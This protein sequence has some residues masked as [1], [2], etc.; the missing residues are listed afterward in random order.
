MSLVA[1]DILAAAEAFASPPL[2]H[3]A[4]AWASLRA[5]HKILWQGPGP[6]G[7]CAAPAGV[8]DACEP[9]LCSPGPRTKRASE[10]S[11]LLMRLSGLVS[12][13]QGLGGEWAQHTPGI[14]LQLSEPARTMPISAKAKHQH[15]L[16]PA[17]EPCL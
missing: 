7:V 2:G 10:A 14:W 13:F 8:A 9:V 16:H 3:C 12:E 17:E 1:P 15:G 11:S 4:Q 5:A 6:W